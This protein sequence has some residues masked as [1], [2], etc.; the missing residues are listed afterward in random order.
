MRKLL[1]YL[2]FTG[3]ILGLGYA[4]Y[5][6]GLNQGSALVRLEWEKDK[7]AARE[8]YAIL[9]EKLIEQEEAYRHRQQ[10]I[11]DDLVQARQQHEV[12]LAD[13]RTD[14]EQRLL[15]S[16]RRAEVYHRQAQSGA[17]LQRDLA[18]HAARL[19][20]ALEE[21]R[22]LV[23]ELSATLELREHQLRLLGEQILTDRLLFEGQTP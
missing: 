12:S 23:R 4:V 9:N 8:T 1:P 2:I 11:T 14:Y 19:D 17:A 16:S 20:R 18:D 3:V 5:R 7:A 10:E 21:G 15:Q 13:Q 6:H 22:E